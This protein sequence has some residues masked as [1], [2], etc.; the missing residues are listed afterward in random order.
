MKMPQCTIYAKSAG[1]E[2]GPY[3]KRQ[4]GKTCEGRI[5]LRFFTM[6]SGSQQIRFVAE[7][8]EAYAL[9]R[10]INKVFQEGTGDALTHKFE[11]SNGEVVTKLGVGKYERNNKAGYAFSVQ[12]GNESINVAVS[13]SD[14]LHAAE[15]LRHLS[16]T[17]AWVEQEVV[18]RK[19]PL[20]S[21][22]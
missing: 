20:Q 4:G 17:E 8:G 11:G 14:F 13:A 22:D 21:S 10:M 7:P 9:F 15:F 3:E 5:S 19:A 12:R 1:V 18:E 16:M 6:E 2:I